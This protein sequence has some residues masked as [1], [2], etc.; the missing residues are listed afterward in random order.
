MTFLNFKKGEQPKKPLTE[1]CSIEE[2]KSEYI[3]SLSLLLPLSL[4]LFACSWVVDYFKLACATYV[5]NFSHLQPT[6]TFGSCLRKM[7]KIDD[8]L[9]SLNSPSH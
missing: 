1:K 7:W 3:P 4:F 9:R 5:A 8:S 6:Y 2:L